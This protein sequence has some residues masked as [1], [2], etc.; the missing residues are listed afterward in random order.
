MENL[1]LMGSRLIGHLRSLPERG[2]W[3]VLLCGLLILVG[4]VF[5]ANRTSSPDLEPLFDGQT[6]SFAELAQM[7]AACSQAALPDARIV[8]NQLHVPRAEQDR[9]L[10]ALQASGALPLAID[11]AVDQAVSNSRLFA[12]PGEIERGYRIAEQKKL[13]RIV[14]N[15]AGIETA[16]VQYDEVKK[17]GLPPTVEVRAFV[18]VRAVGGRTLEFAEIEAIRDTVAGYVAGLER[19][20]V[21]V[22]DLVAC[23]A[24]PGSYDMSDPLA[25]GRA[26]T[27]LK[28]FFEQEYRDNI[29]HR[30]EMYPGAVIGVDVHLTAPP[31]GGGSDGPAASRTRTPLVPSLVRASI[32][33]PRSLITE[34]WRRRTGQ[35]AGVPADTEQ[36]QRV[37]QEICAD[38]QRM[39]SAML[40]PPAA[41]MPSTSQ[42]TVT[43]HWDSQPVEDPSGAL[44]PAVAAWVAEHPAVVG[45][46]VLGLAVVGAFGW[47]YRARLPS[48]RRATDNTAPDPPSA[49]PTVAGPTSRDP[50][51]ESA[52]SDLR[53]TL[54]QLV[55][56]NPQAAAELI[57]NWLDEAA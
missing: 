10:V 39:V 20:D 40:P 14:A 53:E 12:S 31:V 56:Q 11:D 24:Y 37:E 32:G 25:G 42:V 17:G 18:A 9:Y 22:T 49:A 26:Y 15:M 23:R 44:R 16:S 38:I 46:A 8:G 28:R 19:G 5:A 36:L 57:R 41:D 29:Q 13:A 48:R 55:R 35:S 34:L 54:G 4:I 1:A 43:T 7:S 21:T 50:S 2:R 52:D 27:T 33:V 45:L 51:T 47:R 3:A 30:L 6:F